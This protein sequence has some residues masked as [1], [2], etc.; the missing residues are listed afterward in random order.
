MTSKG[1]GLVIEAKGLTKYFGAVRALYNVDFELKRGEIL[2]M[3]GD[4]GAGKSTLLNTIASRF[5][6]RLKASATSYSL[7]GFFSGPVDTYHYLYP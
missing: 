3:V 6:H 1:N 5:N 2:G 7:I 4:N